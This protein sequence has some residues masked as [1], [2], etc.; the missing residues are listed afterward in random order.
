MHVTQ[1]TKYKHFI[2]FCFMS[3]R[4]QF[5]SV[6]VLESRT[7]YRRPASALSSPE[8]KLKPLLSSP[9]R[10]PCSPAAVPPRPMSMSPAQSYAT[11][12]L[13]DVP[14]TGRSPSFIP[15]RPVVIPTPTGP[16]LSLQPRSSPNR[17]IYIPSPLN[18]PSLTPRGPGVQDSFSQSGRSVRKRTRQDTPSDAGSS[19]EFEYSPSCS[20][21]SSSAESDDGST[22]HS[23]IRR[24]GAHHKSCDLASLSKAPSP[25]RYYPNGPVEEED[26]GSSDSEYEDTEVESRF[27]DLRD[28]IDFDPRFNKKV[29]SK[30]D[31][32]TSSSDP[33]RDFLFNHD[34]KSRKWFRTFAWAAVG[35]KLSKKNTEP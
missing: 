5:D 19:S 27:D 35:S 1:T 26:I 20:S 13:M 25:P 3:S 33:L 21:S 10:F 15:V 12:S 34:A 17:L 23:K 14:Q 18:L 22:R 31:K 32:Y 24:L 4:I 7:I 16:S 11:G 30:S 8:S 28:F 2:E 9:S 6:H 29:V